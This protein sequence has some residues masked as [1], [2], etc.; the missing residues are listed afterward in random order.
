MTKFYHPYEGLPPAERAGIQA[1]QLAKLVRGLKAHAPYYQS[2]LASYKNLSPSHYDKPE[3]WQAWL[4][5]LPIVRKADLHGFQTPN[6]PLGGL[7]GIDVT[8]FSLLFASPGPVYEPGHVGDWWRMGQAFHAAGIG[9]GDIMLNCF[10]YHLTP[11]GFM[12]GHAAQTM[13][14]AVIPGGVGQTELQ[15]QVAHHYGANAYCG[16]PDFLKLIVEKAD[17][18]G[19]ALPRLTKALVSG[20]PLFPELRAWYQARNMNVYQCYAAADVGLIGFETQM[21]GQMVV[22]EDI[23]VELLDPNTNLPVADGDIGEVVVTKLDNSKFGLL[24]YATGDLSAFVETPSA[25]GRTNRVLRGWLGRAD[26]ITKIRGMFVHPQQVDKAVKHSGLSLSHYSV[27]VTQNQGHDEAKFHYQTP[28]G[29]ALSAGETMALQNA[30][31]DICRVGVVAWHNSQLSPSCKKID[32]L[33]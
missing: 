2:R 15:G 29:Q 24:R 21:N 16:T 28:H 1:R 25:C 30:L 12:A 27:I 5:S 8:N 26:M 19:I 9:A 31:R 6:L 32:D 23:I 11:A 20:G 18:Q 14:I 22:A 4:Q 7:N 3:S 17:Q 33:R 13:G 10:S